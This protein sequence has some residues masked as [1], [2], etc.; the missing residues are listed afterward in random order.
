M[1]SSS[2]RLAPL[3][4]AL[5]VATAA[6][7]GFRLAGTEPLPAYLT[8][9]RLVAEDTR[10][11]LYVALERRLLRRGVRVSADSTN[12]LSLRDVA[13][14]QRV[15][16]VSAR[17][18]PREYEVFYT[19]SYVFERNGEQLVSRDGFTLTRDY[20]WNETQVLGKEREQELLREIIVDDLVNTIL[21]QIATLG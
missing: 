7:C 15:L 13:T 6:G 8:D 1:S 21:R 20:T 19:V 4:V 5:A 11:D 10:S 16:S 3:C 9:I 12:V 18:I 14:G 17:N 2:G